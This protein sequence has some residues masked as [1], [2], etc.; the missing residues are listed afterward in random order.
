MRKM[1]M[2]TTKPSVAIKWASTI[3]ALSSPPSFH[4]ETKDHR[5]LCSLLESCKRSLDFK[6]VT[7]I[8]A[9]IVK[10]GFGTYPSVIASLV[11]AYKHCDSLSLAYRFLDEVWSFRLVSLNMIIEALMKIQECHIAKKV[12]CKMSDPDVVTWN[13][14]IGGYI[15]NERFEE[16]LRLFKEMLGSNVEPD[17][18]TFASILTGCARLGALSYALW[19][20]N[21]MIERAI[22]LNFILSSALIDMYSKCG[23]IQTAKEVFNSVERSDVS[24]WNAMISGLAIHGLGRD[25]IDIFSKMKVE[26]VLPDSITFLGLLTSSSHCGMVEEGRQ[27]FDLMQSQ[28]SIQPQLE[29]YGAMVDLLGRAGHVEEA[30]SIITSMKMEPDVVI[31]RALLSAC[32]TYKKPD[33][34]EVAI[35]NITR[36]R[37]G[38]YVLLSNMYCSLKRWDSAE[39]VRE[40]M[41]KEG[42]RKNRGKSWL[43]LAGVI[44]Q[45]KA[46]DRSHPQTEAVE[47]VLGGL[48]QRAK[49]EGLL[50]ATE[51]VLMDVSEEEKEENLYLHSEKVAL[52]YGILK[53]SPGT[54]IRISK[55]LRICYDCHSF[56]KIISKLLNRVT[57]VRDRIRF[58]RFEGGLCSCGDYW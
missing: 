46:G 58:H 40:I 34:G 24:V 14:M 21:V 42:V 12:F 23:R 16:A 48:I 50:P 49:L 39:R 26:N 51:L 38:D 18:F 36:L 44:H 11:S 43:E 19:V 30:F 41:K 8:H 33:L 35:A 45:F 52:A 3:H 17:K 10:L 56:I 54:E 25:A 32:R 27:Y 31:W 15:R 47:K 13:S 29:H 57:I 4:I 2:L 53:T 28:Y 20:H 9:R 37:G 55:N 5:T 1:T 6:I 7:E 22:E